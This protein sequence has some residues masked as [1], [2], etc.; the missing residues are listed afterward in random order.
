M[1]SPSGNYANRR[2]ISTETHKHSSKEKAD[3]Q[4]DRPERYRN[5]LKHTPD[6]R[7]HANMCSYRE[8][9]VSVS[10]QETAHRDCVL[11][12]TSGKRVLTMA[13]EREYI[14]ELS[15][16]YDDEQDFYDDAIFRS[17]F[18]GVVFPRVQR[19]RSAQPFIRRAEVA[20]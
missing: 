16:S 17:R 13:A 19:H 4:T 3:S 20:R 7:K 11:K 18:A 10:G 8:S 15:S 9:N 1:L 14:D 2:M 6:K 5:T 12:R